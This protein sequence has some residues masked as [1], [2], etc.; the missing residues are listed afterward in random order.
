MDF[1]ESSQMTLDIDPSIQ[2][3]RVAWCDLHGQIRSKSMPAGLIQQGLQDISIGMVGTLMLKDTSD[4]T[5]FKVFEPSQFNQLGE[6]A[7]FANASNLVLKLADSA[8]RLHP[9]P[10]TSPTA[11]EAWLF[12][13]PF[14]SDGAPVGLDARRVLQAAIAKLQTAGYAMRCG[15]EIE[16][17]IYKIESETEALNPEAAAWPGLAP[18][19]S[20]LHPGY[21]LLSDAYTDRCH[22]PM[23]IIRQTALGLG[24]PL[25][26]LEIEFGPSQFEAVFDVQD[27]LTAADS[28]VLFTN[29]VRQALRRAGYHATF[30]C[31]PPFANIMSS[32]WHLHQSL[33]DATTGK[34][35]P[36]SM[37]YLAG[38]IQHGRA[39]AAFAA[40]TVSSYARYQPNVLA[41]H[42]VS[43]GMDSRAA[44]LRVLPNRIEN[45]LGEPMA[46]PYLYIA[47]QIYA[48]LHG[49]QAKLAVPPA[50][51]P[52]AKPLPASLT[53]AL[54]A[55]EADAVYSAGFGTDFITYYSHIKRFEI[56]RFEAVDDKL[57]WL[58]SEYFNRF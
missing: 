37:H 44:M 17:H 58:T 25:T 47:S 22:A 54:D 40:P 10:W 12:A 38:L 7:K 29:G 21:Q 41:P 16:F 49:L 20:L 36:V 27:A 13:E 33:V 19:V 14:F 30:M 39:M 53:E 9:L 8:P 3:I 34:S 35:E 46:N 51:D 43:W 50:D 31:R 48:G 6:A 28:M 1:D 15:L 18:R 11:R 45:R 56:A 2:T 52:A 23:E 4:H 24:L 42:T 32:G 57:A 5:A 55:L 26:S